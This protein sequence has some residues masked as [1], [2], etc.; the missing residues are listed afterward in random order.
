MHN[1]D[2]MTVIE[3]GCLIMVIIIGAIIGITDQTKQD[4]YY[5]EITY[6]RI[7]KNDLNQLR[8]YDNRY[9]EL[10]NAEYDHRL[11]SNKKIYIKSSDGN[12]WSWFG[13][14]KSTNLGATHYSQK[15]RYN[16]HILKQHGV[17]NGC[18]VMRVIFVICTVLSYN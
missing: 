2:K 15:I 16:Q 3:I 12:Y 14:H 4:D 13:N 9:A 10:A 6:K 7:Y 17:T 1:S 5:N 11:H 18:R 8:D